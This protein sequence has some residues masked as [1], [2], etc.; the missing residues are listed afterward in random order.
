M[1][2]TAPGDGVNLASRAEGL[3]KQYGT[4]ILVTEAIQEAAAPVLAFRRLDRMAVK[5]KTKGTLVYELLGPADLPQDRLATARAY[6]AALDL[7]FAEHF[8]AA[9]ARFEAV[10]DDP[11]SQALAERCRQMIAEP[12]PHDGDGIVVSAVK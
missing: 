6:E 11:P 4:T 2:F 9:H 3:N 12:P 1:S 10:P 8:T 7:Y 5:G